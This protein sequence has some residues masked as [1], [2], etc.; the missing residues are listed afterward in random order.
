MRRG[1]R[2]YPNRVR[3]IGGRWRGTRIDVL[4]ET[5]LRPTPDRVRETLF[6]WLSAWI[7]GAR[8]LDLY[9]GTGVLGLE[10]L[11]RGASSACFVERDERLA[12]A[13]ARRARSL[14]ANA[15]VVCADAMAYLDTAAAASFDIAFVD[16]PYELALSPVLA[17]LS[18]RGKSGALVYA[19]RPAAEELP[20]VGG[21]QWLKHSRAGAVRYG[22][23]RV[24]ER[25]D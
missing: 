20:A 8:C 21:L 24:D 15:E 12:A 5:T 4:E 23:A 7:A 16:P 19:E 18:E 17:K 14:G 2:R 25:S 13:I 1:K 11:S 22:L 3:I 10:A 6:N 9:A